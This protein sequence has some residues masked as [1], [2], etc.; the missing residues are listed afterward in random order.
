MSFLYA[1]QVSMHL[2]SQAW[3]CAQL[4]PSCRDLLADPY[5]QAY[6]A[7]TSARLARLAQQQCCLMCCCLTLQAALSGGGRWKYVDR[8]NDLIVTYRMQAQLA[9]VLQEVQ[10]VG[11]RLDPKTE[12]QLKAAQ[13]CMFHRASEYLLSAAPASSHRA[14]MFACSYACVLGF[15]CE[16]CSQFLSMRGRSRPN[17]LRVVK[18]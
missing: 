5:V 17:T 6:M 2:R 11:L 7:C 8:V 16:N 18:L 13:P 10:W 1:P 9:R 15:Q 3:Q 14:A 4:F 12:V